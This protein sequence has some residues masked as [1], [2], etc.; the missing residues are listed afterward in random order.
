MIPLFHLN[1]T[2]WGLKPLN[3]EQRFA[4]ELLLCNDFNLVTLIGLP[5]AG[6]TL[7]ALACGLHK[8]VEE[9]QFRRLFISRPIIPMGRDIGFLPGSKEEKLSSWMG[10]IHDNLEYL[11]DRSKS[12]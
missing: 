2:P 5:G 6:K 3:I 8:T 10:A 12:D 11:V 4:I 7:L 9:H 1:A